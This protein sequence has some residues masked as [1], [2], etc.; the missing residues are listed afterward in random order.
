[1]T[2]WYVFGMLLVLLGSIGTAIKRIKVVGWSISITGLVIS[3]IAVLIW[4]RS[5]FN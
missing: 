1:M 5:H 2:T 3:L 4:Y